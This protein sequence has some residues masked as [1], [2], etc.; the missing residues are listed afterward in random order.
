[1]A[2]NQMWKY[3]SVVLMLLL[4]LAVVS[5]GLLYLNYVKVED[6]RTPDEISPSENE[7]E[8]NISNLKD[9]IA[10][11]NQTIEELEALIREQRNESDSGKSLENGT[12]KVLRISGP[13]DS[14]LVGPTIMKLRNWR[15]NGNVSGVLLW[16]DSPG[17][18]VGS[19]QQ[20]YESIR[21]FS[22]V[23]PIVTYSGGHMLSGAYYLAQ[24]SDYI[25]TRSRASVGSI[26]VLY[27]HYNYKQNLENNDIEVTVFKTGEHKDTGA[28][29]RGLTEEEKD[30][31]ERSIN[32]NFNQF[33]GVISDSTGMNKT[34]IKKLADGSS[35]YGSY[36]FREGLVDDIGGLEEALDEVERFSD[37]EN[38]V[39]DYISIGDEEFSS[40]TNLRGFLYM[41]PKYLQKS[42]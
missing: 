11:K 5:S 2:D 33:L 20:I 30:V 42:E 36:M 14:S 3:I 10:S 38:H 24:A 25:V 37:R 27:V 13:L 12:I 26:G 35:Y 22:L 31:V 18:T 19:S 6:S 17:G 4:A 16:I 32:E 23:K 1:M 29:W 21:K 7:Y 41:D 8:R 9:E 34:Q 40:G 15:K 28:P 39:I